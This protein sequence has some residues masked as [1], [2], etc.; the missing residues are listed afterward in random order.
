VRDVLGG[1]AVEAVTRSRAVA[2]LVLVDGPD[3]HLELLAGSG[4]PDGL[5]ETVRRA[6]LRLVGLPGGELLATGRLMLVSDGRAR[7]AAAPLTAP[8]A[9]RTADL[10]WGGAVEVPLHR[11]GVVVGCL[12]LL[13]PA[14]LTAPTKGEL[15]AWSALGAHASVALAEERLREQAASHAAELERHRLGR[16][17]HDSVIAALFSLHTRAQAV[18]RGLDAGDVG[19]V[20]SAAE[21]LEELARQAVAELR[22]MVTDMRVGVV[23]VSGGAAGSAARAHALV[24]ERDGLRVDLPH[25]AR[26]GSTQRSGRAPGEDRGRGAAQLREALRRPRGAGLPGGPRVE[27]VLTVSDQ[28]RGFDPVSAAGGHGLRI[29]QERA[30]LCGGVLQVDSAPSR[31]PRGRAHP[32]RRLTRRRGARPGRP[33]GARRSRGRDGVQ[34]L[35]PCC[36]PGR[37]DGGQHADDGAEGEEQRQPPPGTT[38]SV[39]PW[40]DSARVRLVP[41]RPPSPSPSAEP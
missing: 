41:S 17:L 30:L 36:P 28:G 10:G 2:C 1:L 14:A 19:V 15:T 5:G 37:P 20:R 35:H 31:Y 13:L 11:G 18:R 3:G 12:V 40:S 7:F 26:G 29:M 8:I 34:H 4:L 24:H 23:V 6:G 32:A 22:A 39:M 21:D 25:R 27:C 16:D 9:E 33:C 38:S